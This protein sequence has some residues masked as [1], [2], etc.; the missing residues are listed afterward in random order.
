M[1]SGGA[2]ILFRRLD[3]NGGGKKTSPSNEVCSCR[4]LGAAPSA[5]TAAFSDGRCGGLAPS[6]GGPQGASGGG[7]ELQ[8]CMGKYEPTIVGGEWAKK[9][10]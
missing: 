10:F 9:S 5:A 1:S 4:A 2:P 3:Y 8:G 6:S 7:A